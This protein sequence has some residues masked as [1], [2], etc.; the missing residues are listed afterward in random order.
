MLY[1]IQG[2]L[3]SCERL[4][5]TATA[6]K[7]TLILSAIVLRRQGGGAASWQHREGTGSDAARGGGRCSPPSSLCPCCLQGRLPHP[8]FVSHM[9]AAAGGWGLQLVCATLSS[10][11]LY[12]SAPWC[13]GS[14]PGRL[15]RTHSAFPSLCFPYRNQ[16][17]CFTLKAKW[18]QTP[19]FHLQTVRF[20]L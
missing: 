19:L 15:S 17:G 8:L 11:L 10:T 1:S 3:N 18:S 14:G 5:A 12:V 2:M 9:R 7:V 6:K 13:R 4:S 20:I 16:P